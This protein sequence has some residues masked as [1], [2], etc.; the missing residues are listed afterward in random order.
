MWAL[1]HWHR[2]ERLIIQFDKGSFLSKNNQIKQQG[3]GNKP[4]EHIAG[5]VNEVQEG[6]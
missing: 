4:T 1:N 5:L 6:L 3:R 2:T